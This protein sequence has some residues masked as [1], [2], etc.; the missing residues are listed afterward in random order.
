MAD[1]IIKGLKKAIGEY[2]WANNNSDPSWYAK[3]MYDKSTGE[4][5]ADCF[6]SLGHNTWKEYHDSDIIDLGSLMHEGGYP[7]T[8][9]GVKEFLPV[10]SKHTH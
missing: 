5:W 9:K 10:M 2:K 4:I 1:L 6:Y 8:M 3:L 7:I